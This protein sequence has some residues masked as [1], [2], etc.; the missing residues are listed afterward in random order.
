[1]AFTQQQITALEA[2]IASGTLSVRYGDRQVT[3]Q[4]LS[5]MRRLLRQMRGEIATAAGQR[6]RRRSIRLYQSGTG[7]V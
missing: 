6:A 5:E 7:N 4:S 3:Y 2:A 1:M